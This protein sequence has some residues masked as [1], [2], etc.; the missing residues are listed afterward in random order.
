[1][2]GKRLL[3]ELCPIGTF[4][5]AE[6]QAFGATLNAAIHECVFVTAHLETGDIQAALDALIQIRLNSEAI[7][8]AIEQ[9]FADLA[10]LA[11]THEMLGQLVD[12]AGPAAVRRAVTQPKQ[13]H[14]EHR[15]PKPPG[16]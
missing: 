3:P 2:K 5:E 15:N 9:K 11:P 13:S 14:P 1:M 12:Q 7:H 10:N 8:E 4:T 16:R 6:L